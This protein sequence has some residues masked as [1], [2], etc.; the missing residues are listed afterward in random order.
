MPI[1]TQPTAGKP[2][3]CTKTIH[4]APPFYMSFIMT[5]IV[6]SELSGRM[7]EP[8]HASAD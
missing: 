6:L 4:F 2:S 1:S 5:I 7:S 8:I 3:G